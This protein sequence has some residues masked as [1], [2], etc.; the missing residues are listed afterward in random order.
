MNLKK[1]EIQEFKMDSCRYSYA[2]FSPDGK[3][4]IFGAENG[5]IRVSRD[6]N[7]YFQENERLTKDIVK[8]IKSINV[9]D[10]LHR[11]E[12]CE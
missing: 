6:I 10:Y 5:T 3:Y 12:M 11:I 9:Y 1:E 2:T 7:N 4:S 8:A